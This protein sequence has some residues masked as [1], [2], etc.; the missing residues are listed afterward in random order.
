MDLF[1]KCA[2]DQMTAF[3]GKPAALVFPTGYQTNLGTIAA[4]VGRS[5]VVIADKQN[6][7]SIVDVCRLSFGAVKRFSHNSEEILGE[8]LDIS[9]WAGRQLGIIPPTAP[10]LAPA[11]IELG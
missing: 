6:H 8:V 11:A 5:D 2:R 4:L 9:A 10:E 3:F 7:A 1:D